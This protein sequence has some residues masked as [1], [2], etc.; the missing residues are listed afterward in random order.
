MNDK[1][2]KLRKKLTDNQLKFSNLIH[3]GVE[4]SK[5]YRQA[6]NTKSKRIS[7]QSASR[8]LTT[9]DKVI[10]Y[11]AALRANE[12]RKTSISRSMQLNRLNKLFRL[13]LD[14]DN[15]TAGT[16]V[17]REQN[18]MLGYHRESAPNMEKEQ[19][20]QQRIAEEKE[21]LQRMSRQRTDELSSDEPTVKKI[22]R[23]PA[24]R[25]GAEV[26]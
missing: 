7:Q 20:K 4:R 5:A 19:A 16:S 23:S 11:L 22:G 21:A 9:N 13:A 14:Q 18:E 8:L 12:D 3:S 6:F 1:L 25:P 10:D 17:I 24:L 26:G 2:S 15:V